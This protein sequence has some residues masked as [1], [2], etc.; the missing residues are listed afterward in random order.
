MMIFIFV[1]FTLIFLLVKLI[2]FLEFV[3]C[4]FFFLELA[5]S[6]FSFVKHV[7][8]WFFSLWSWHIGFPPL[9]TDF[10][11]GPHC[12]PIVFTLRTCCVLNFVRETC[13]TLVCSL[14]NLY[15]DFYPRKTDFIYGTYS[16]LIFVVETCCMI[17]SLFVKLVHWFFYSWKFVHGLQHPDFCSW[18]LSRIELIA[19]W[20]F[21]FL[22]ITATWLLFVEPL[23]CWFSFEK[24]VACSFSLRETCTLIFFSSCKCFVH[25]T[26]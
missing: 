4:W 3:A 9:E 20:F 12:M 2:L 17:I 11:H 22:E 5:V 14:W 19:R 18:S 13:C 6:W 7:A 23:A 16:M 24:H 8:R 26:W 10:L 1:I 25:E 21:S 15:I